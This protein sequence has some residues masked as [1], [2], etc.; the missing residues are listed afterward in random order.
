MDNLKEQ[1]AN[2]GILIKSL[3][4]PTFLHDIRN[5]VDDYFCEPLEAYMSMSRDEFQTRAV[6]CQAAI[7]CR[8][9]QKAFYLSEK[10]TLDEI[11]PGEKLLFESVVFLRAVRP[12]TASN[13]A[14]NPDFHR[15][16]MYSDHSHTKHVLNVW[17]PIKNVDERNTLKYVPKSHL[18]EDEDLTVEYNERATGK[19]EKYSAGHNFG[20]LWRPKSIKRGVDLDR[21][22]GMPF[23]EDSYAIF[24]SMLVHG[25]GDNHSNGIRFALGFG[26][27]AE[28]KMGYNKEFF[29]SGGKQHYIKL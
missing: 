1:L 13:T 27:I 19:V 7:N 10:E 9:V 26:I 20:F 22:V 15:E 16:S 24:S 4:A 11:L 8:E 23:S 5:I 2:E 29:A 14:E 21:A 17:C 12:I 28:E 6:E 18:I 25:G 3:Q